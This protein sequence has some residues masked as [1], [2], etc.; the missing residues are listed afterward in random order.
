MRRAHCIPVISFG[1]AMAAVL[2]ASARAPA[3]G[4]TWPQIRRV[5][6]EVNQSLRESAAGVSARAQT[7]AE[8]PRLA[9]ATATDRQT[10]ADLTGEE[11]AIRPRAS[12]TIEL[13]QVP[14]T[15]GAPLSLLR[16]PRDAASTMPL[17]SPGVH[18][19]VSQGAL[20]VAS[21]V[22]IRPPARSDEIDGVVAVSWPADMARVARQVAALGSGVTLETQAGTIQIGGPTRAE[23]QRVAVPVAGPSGQGLVL[24]APAPAARG[25][26]PRPLAAALGIALGTLVSA[27]LIFG[28]AVAAERR[29]RAYELEAWATR[30]WTPAPPARPRTP[31]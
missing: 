23:A 25:W 1:A 15:G 20:R 26:R 28:G 21:V 3:E 11:L 24:I 2:L 22:R 7:L 5:A 6:A 27:S 8:L 9:L 14:R 12:E 31:M 16:F 10:V 17:A 30:T 13:A 4:P 19:I 29:A 18:L